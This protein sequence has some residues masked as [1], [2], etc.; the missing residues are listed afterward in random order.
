MTDPRFPE[1]RPPLAGPTSSQPVYKGLRPPGVSRPELVSFAR[2]VVVAVLIALLL[3]A[4]GGILYRGMHVLLETFAGILFAVFLGTLSKWLSQHTRLSYGWALTLVVLVFLFVVAGLGWLLAN[5]VAG[6]MEAMQQKL[7]QSLDKVREFLNQHAWGKLL[8]EN[9]PRDQAAWASLVQFA[10]ITDVVTGL[11]DFL[12]AGVI[13]FFVGVFGAAEPD[14][15]REGLLHLVPP[16]QRPR[17]AEAVDAVV[18]NLRWWLV[19]QVALM[20][21]IGVTTFVGLLLLRI[22]LALTLGV[23][24]GIMELVPYLGPW[25]SAVPAAL[26]A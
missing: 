8:A 23:I 26:L 22:P 14:L 1:S 6:Q 5:R 13:I 11:M 19:G 25:I 21:I 17:A 16:R 24:A 15:Y 10:R 9:F 2:R 3:V 20:V 7:P 12:V 18:F 4:L